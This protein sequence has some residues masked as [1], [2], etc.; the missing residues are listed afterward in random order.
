MK[1][2][3]PA[4]GAALRAARREGRHPLCVH[5]IFGHDWKAQT[6][7]Q[8][9]TR[10]LAQ[11]EAHP[12]LAVKPEDFERG[13]FDWSVV[14]G[15]NVAVFNQNPSEFGVWVPSQKDPQFGVWKHTKDDG[16]YFK[17]WWLVGELGQFAAE[18]EVHANGMVE[19]ADAYA[20][21]MKWPSWPGW[22]PEATETQNAKRR[23]V[24]FR[25]ASSRVGA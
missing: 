22:W 21:S 13:R 11:G 1:L 25:Y 3:L 6:F 16:D 18:I 19:T 5:V 10:L 7:C 14:A 23:Q 17:L 4:Y 8:P 20:L 12:V 9:L 24:W 15:L 2:K